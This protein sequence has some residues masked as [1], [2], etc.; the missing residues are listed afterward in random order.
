MLTLDETPKIEMIE[1]ILIAD[2]RD[3]NQQPKTFMICSNMETDY[4]ISNQIVDPDYTGI[5]GKYVIAK[6]AVKEINGV[7]FL[8]TYEIRKISIKK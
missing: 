4:R 7:L 8:E 6:G 2:F 1:G 5:L 3:E